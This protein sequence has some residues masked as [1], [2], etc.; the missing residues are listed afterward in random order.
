MKSSPRAKEW[1]P[2][3][4]TQIDWDAI[5]N[6]TGD[7]VGTAVGGSAAPRPE[8]NED[9]DAGPE[10]AEGQRSEPEFLTVGLIGAVF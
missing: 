8:S 5:R 2:S 4:K 6:A 1:K 3:V 7:K 9:D 10:Q